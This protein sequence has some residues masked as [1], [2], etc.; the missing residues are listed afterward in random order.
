MRLLLV[1]GVIAGLVGVASAQPGNT[2]PSSWA[3]QP[4][5]ATTTGPVPGEKSPG[6]ALGLSLGGTALSIALTAADDDSD[7]GASLG[8]IGGI[9]LWVAPSFGHWYSG[10]MWTPGLTARLAGTGAAVIGALMLVTCIDSDGDCDSEGP[11]IVL[12]L[13]GAGAIVGGGIYDIATAPE[14]A[15][16]YN[17]RLREQSATRQWALTPSVSRDRAGFVLGGRF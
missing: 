10:K 1:I 5:L 3:P 16:K 15:R 2:P 4:P 14:E 7:S 9:G 8:A 12:L 6:L 13:G 17:A 11:G